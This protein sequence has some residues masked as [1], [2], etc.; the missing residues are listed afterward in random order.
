MSSEATPSRTYADVVAGVRSGTPDS[1]TGISQPPA[2]P[3]SV[4]ADDLSS[5]V[6]PSSVGD[7]KRRKRSAPRPR[8]KAAT[9]KP[10]D[11]DGN[12]N[13][14][15]R[16]VHGRGETQEDEAQLGL[17]SGTETFVVCLVVLVPLAYI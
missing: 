2:R 11:L 5:V 8:R 14:G 12:K 1:S 3:L 17:S 9:D 4:N 7:D 13:E 16:K 10:V 6:R 15:Q